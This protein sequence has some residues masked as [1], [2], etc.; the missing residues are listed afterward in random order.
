[1]IPACN[2][3]A[4][5]V[6]INQWQV[7]PSQDSIKVGLAKDQICKVL[8][9]ISELQVKGFMPGLQWSI[10]RSFIQVIQLPSC[11]AVLSLPCRTCKNI[12]IHDSS[13]VC[14]F[15]APH[16]LALKHLGCSLYIGSPS[17]RGLLGDRLRSWAIFS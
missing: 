9:L 11:M 8:H 6:W 13:N 2:D 14:G 7:I 1:M 12:P 4:Y 16:S 10:F 15:T 17:V 5:I 3:V